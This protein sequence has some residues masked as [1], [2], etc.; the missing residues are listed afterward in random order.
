MQ[1]IVEPCSVEDEVKRSRF[2]AHALPVQSPEEAVALLGEVRDP[3]ATHNTWAYKVGD[4][5]R[6]SDDGEPGGTAG[7]PILAAI[8]QVGVDRVLVVVTRYFGGI[9]L[10]SG[11][12]VRAY[13]G[14]AARCL[15]EARKV[16]LAPH[17]L[18]EVQ[19]PFDLLGA[20]Y[21]AAERNG[22]AKESERYTESGATLTFCVDSSREGAVTLALRDA[23]S[24]KLVVAR[25]QEVLRP[26]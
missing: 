5:Y 15:R 23:S 18:L 3:R 6:F 22:A 26:V 21:H 4:A 16:T 2:V 7:R 9:K 11:G 12:L 19:V 25:R 13:G 1:I 8:E 17:V 14:C 24:G 10:G 20:A